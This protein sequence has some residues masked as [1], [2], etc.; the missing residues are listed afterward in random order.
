MARRVPGSPELGA[1][2]VLRGNKTPT[3]PMNV[4]RLI[5]SD[6]EAMYRLR[7]HALESDPKGFRESLEE[8]RTVAVAT[9]AE[10]LGTNAD[11]NF[12]LGAYDD[13]DSDAQKII[14]MVGFYREQQLKC[15]HKGWIWGMFVV[16]NHRG[17]RIGR[18]LVTQ[19][20][21]N[22]RKISGLRTIRLTVSTT[23]EAAR[24]LYANCGFRVTGLEPQAMIVS[25]ESIDEEQMMLDL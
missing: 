13:Q 6:A 7:L 19:A 24:K 16:E 14:G 15:R 8:L 22:A 20:V 12:V 1:I 10:R 5:A 21:A 18:A 2:F 23:Q 4:R 17:K 9:Y 25:G 11:D 3:F